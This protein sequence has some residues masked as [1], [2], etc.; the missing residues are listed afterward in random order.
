MYII[1]PKSWKIIVIRKQHR[2]ELARPFRRELKKKQKKN[3]LVTYC[4]ILNCHL[5]MYIWLYFI[6][7]VLY[8]IMCLK[9]KN[10]QLLSQNWKFMNLA[11]AANAVG[12]IRTKKQKQNKTK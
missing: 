4:S 7:S 12:R 9:W 1:A 6:L 10:N 11:K 5:K 3:W 8:T 2:N